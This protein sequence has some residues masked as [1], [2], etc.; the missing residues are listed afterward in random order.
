MRTIKYHS[1]IGE[2]FNTATVILPI[3]QYTNKNS[4]ILSVGYNSFVFINWA[5]KILK[6]LDF[7]HY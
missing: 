2:Q 3:T 6:I 7:F 4:E 5:K 1:L